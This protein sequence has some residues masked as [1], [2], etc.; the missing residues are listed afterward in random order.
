MTQ[1]PLRERVLLMLQWADPV[2]GVT[3]TTLCKFLNHISRPSRHV[4]LST[5]SSLLTKMYDAGDLNRFKGA[6]PRDGFGYT[7]ARTEKKDH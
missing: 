7:L 3:A 5:L 2:T 1:A 4:K 6:G